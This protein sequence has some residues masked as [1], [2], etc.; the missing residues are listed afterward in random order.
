MG[1]GSGVS[2]ARAGAETIGVVGVSTEVGIVTIGE[3]RRTSLIV[4]VFGE[5][6]VEIGSS[7]KS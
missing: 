2:S 6:K 1:I 4:G 3:I 5:F 7:G